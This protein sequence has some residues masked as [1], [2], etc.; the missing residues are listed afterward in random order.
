M[1]SIRLAR[2]GAKKRPYYNIVVAEKSFARDG[3][4]IERLGAADPAIKGEEGAVILKMERYQHWFQ[5]GAKPTETVKRWVRAYHRAN[6]AAA[7]ASDNP[8][9]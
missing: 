4:F 8:T 9:S 5:R 6:N 2:G 3:R 7:N 1:L